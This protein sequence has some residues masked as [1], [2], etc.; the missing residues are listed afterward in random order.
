MSP[1]LGPSAIVPQDRSNMRRPFL[2]ALPEMTEE[3]VCLARGAAG[4]Q[5]VK[6]SEASHLGSSL[7]FINDGLESIS[8]SLPGGKRQ[9]KK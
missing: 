6:C 1:P 2:R 8:F 4:W 7:W 5:E 9:T 3:G